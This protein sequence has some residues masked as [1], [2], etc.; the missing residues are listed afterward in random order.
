MVCVPL[1]ST[2][3]AWN[4]GCSQNRFVLSH[5][6]DQFHGCDL[7]ANL[8][9]GGFVAECHWNSLRIAG[10]RQ[11]ASQK[12]LVG[13]KRQVGSKSRPLRQCTRESVE[14]VMPRDF[15]KQIL[16]ARDIDAMAR[17][18]N[19]PAVVGVLSYV[20]TEPLKYAFN[21]CVFHRHSEKSLDLLTAK[22]RRRNRKAYFRDRKSTRL[23][24]S[25]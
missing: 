3:H 23:N 19:G 4:Q 18:F 21:D 6:V 7:G 10:C 17:N 1:D 8:S 24:S 5:G 2:Q 16:F 15:V 11:P 22:C 25:H 14:A 9:L 13:F 12:P 20:E